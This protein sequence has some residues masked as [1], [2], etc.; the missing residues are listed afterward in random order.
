MVSK[1]NSSLKKKDILMPEAV[2]TSKAQILTLE[3]IIT[4]VETPWCDI[5]TVKKSKLRHSLCRQQILAIYLKCLRI[6]YDQ[7]KALRFKLN[8]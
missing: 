3:V 7:V 2:L 6:L 8:H 4:L 5:E 1:T